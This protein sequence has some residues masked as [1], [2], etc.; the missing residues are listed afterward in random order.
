MFTTFKPH[1]K[2]KAR[3]LKNQMTPAEK[4]LWFL[5]LRNQAS[6]KFLRQK[7]IGNYIVDFYCAAKKLVIELDGDSH[8]VGSQVWRDLQRQ[9]I[10][11][12]NFGIRVLR[13]GN[14]EVLESFESVFFEIERNLR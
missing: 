8:F 14:F 12:E 10:L 2:P 6:Q 13:F 9:K 3:E 5:F 11:Q 7:P 4:K 1:L